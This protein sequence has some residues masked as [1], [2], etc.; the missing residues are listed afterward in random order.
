MDFVG[1]Q[2]GHDHDAGAVT[3]IYDGP[4]SESWQRTPIRPIVNLEPP[5]EDHRAYS[6]GDRLDAF[7]VRRAIY[8]SLLNAPPVGV[9]YGAHGIWSWENTAG[10]P[11]NHEGSGVARPWDEAVDLPGGEDVRHVRDLFSSIDWWTLRPDSTLVEAQPFPDDPLRHVSAST[12]PDDRL[13]VVYLPGGGTVEL[14]ASRLAESVT[15]R[16][17]DPRTGETRAAS[18]AGSGTFTAPDRNDWILLF[19]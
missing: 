7:D 18:G 15:A 9:S 1:Y 5:Y 2:S 3:W 13:G 8:L 17:F 11:L 12:G 16:W 19:D 6:S 10:E 14:D 4:A